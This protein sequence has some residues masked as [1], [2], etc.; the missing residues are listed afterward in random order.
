[1]TGDG[2]ANR[3]VGLGGDDVL[4]GM[5]GQNV[6]LGGD[7][8]D[9]LRGGGGADVLDGG[10]GIDTISY[11][12]SYTYGAVRVDL[13]SGLA[14]GHDAQRDVFSGIENVEGTY[15][16]DDV[17]T[18]DAGANTLTGIG[19]NDTLSGGA[20]NDL[21]NG[22]IGADV[23]NGGAGSDVATYVDSAAAVVVNLTAGT[24]TG[25]DAQGDV[26][27]GVENVNGSLGTDTLTGNASATALFGDAG[28]DILRGGGGA[29]ALDGGTGTDLVS[30]YDSSAGVTAN[31]ATGAGTGGDAQGDVLVGI[32]NVNGSQLADSLTGSAG[33]NALAGYGGDDVLRGGAGA[34]A[35]DGGNG[36]DL[37]SYFDSSAGV[38]VNLSTG[39]GTGG[40]AQGDTFANVENVNGSTSA[41]TLTGNG[42]AN[43]LNGWTGQDTMTGLA[44]ADR[45]VFTAASHSA[46]GANAD[47]ITD[48]SHAQGDKIDLSTIDANTGLAGDQ[49]FSF[50]GTG[51]YTDVAGQLR[52]SVVGSTTTIAG[53]LNGDG[54]SD[55]HIALS[56]A[57]GLVAADFVL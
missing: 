22:G 18:G 48:F 9:L 49:A 6:L 7:G 25:G 8:N 21:L 55:F 45:F 56:G 28:N 24:G 40:D 44:G 20:G 41:D 38:T 27:V 3:L 31:L 36:I 1:M 47:R 2:G 39:A 34:D 4:D 11:S 51:A 13:S 42:L 29:D 53:D 37:A 33:A 43:V 12:T 17:L 57:I 30:Y 15:G 54:T 19:G 46:V 26:L 14:I 32:E 50:I 23:L 16:Y 35:L 5:D 10:A 52:Y